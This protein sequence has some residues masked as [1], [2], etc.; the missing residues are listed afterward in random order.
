MAKQEAIDFLYTL[1]KPCKSY[2][3]ATFYESL[4][5]YRMREQEKSTWW[6]FA[7][8]KYYNDLPPRL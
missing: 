5:N 8:N 4:P 2:I 6:A 3:D 1:D 7:Q